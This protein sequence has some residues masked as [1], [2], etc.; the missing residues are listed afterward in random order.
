MHITRHKTKEIRVGSVA[1]GGRAPVSVQTMTKTDTR[2]VRATVRQ[3]REVEA[4]GCDIVR[5]A[6]PDMEAARAFAKIKKQVR[7]P[8]I[9]DIH[10]DYKLA[11]ETLNGGADGIR[12]NP[13]NLGG[14][15]RLKK[16]IEAARRWGVSI[17]V[18]VNSGAG[19][20]C[21]A[22]CPAHRR[23]WIRSDQDFRQGIGCPAHA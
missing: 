6:I 18:G 1:V 17:R 14:I 4:L 22:Q 19:G 15:D 16:V 7:I 10:F 23:F 20:E 21:A 2:D 5:L 12:I 8:L 9:A 3:I 11:L 13:G